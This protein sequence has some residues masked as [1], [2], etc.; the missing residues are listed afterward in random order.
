MDY[1]KII[2]KNIPAKSY[3]Y[4]DEL[5]VKTK[6][7]KRDKFD[8]SLVQLNESNFI[9]IGVCQDIILKQSYYAFLQL[10]KQ[11]RSEFIYHWLPIVISIIALLKSFL[12][13]IT[14]LWNILTQ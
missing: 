14:L 3:I 10:E 12:P 8:Y 7:K 2:M 13:E 11:K 9:S 1:C 4:A 5:F 6:L